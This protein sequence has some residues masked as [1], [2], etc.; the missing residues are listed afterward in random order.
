[1]AER[2][3]TLESCYRVTQTPYW[4]PTPVGKPYL[5]VALTGQANAIQRQHAYAYSLMCLIK[6][7]RGCD[8]PCDYLPLAWRDWEAELEKQGFG[9]G[10]FGPYYPNRKRCK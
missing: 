3:I 10:G 9:A 1:M 5:S 4:F 7:G 2:L 6:P 8:L